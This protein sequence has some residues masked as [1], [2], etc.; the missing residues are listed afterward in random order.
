MYEPTEF[1]PP[2]ELS[3]ESLA[4]ENPFDLTASAY[5]TS[6]TSTSASP[7]A[8]NTLPQHE[9]QHSP[10]RQIRALKV[11]IL[12]AL[13]SLDRGLAANVSVVAEALCM[14]EHTSSMRH[15]ATHGEWHALCPM[16]IPHALYHPIIL[17]MPLA[18]SCKAHALSAAPLLTRASCG[19]GCWPLQYTSCCMQV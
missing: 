1:K 6:P 5:R 16:T 9:K 7:S 18:P 15:A 17:H 8:P 11:Q 14:R 2:K 12:A 19:S 4:G 10:Q 3:K 13:S